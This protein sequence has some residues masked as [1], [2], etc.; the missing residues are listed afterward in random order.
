MSSLIKR[1][2]ST[3][4]R[5]LKNE[6]GIPLDLS[7]ITERILVCSCP[8]SKFPQKLYRNSLNDL[9]NYMEIK[10]SDNWSLWN[11]KTENLDDY[12]WN[13]KLLKGK[14]YHFPWPDHQ[15][16]PFQ[17]LLN[18]VK[19]IHA[20]LLKDP[21]N[22]AVLH[23]K[24]GK[25]RS[26][27][28]ATAY[29]IVYGALTKSEACHLF[30]EKRMNLGFGEGISILSQLKYLDYCSIYINRPYEPQVSPYI[31]HIRV[32]GCKIPRSALNLTIFSYIGKDYEYYSL[33]SIK[34]SNIT[35]QNE[36][37]CIYR[38]NEKIQGQDIRI[39]I[40][41][42]S[43]SPFTNSVSTWFNTYWETLGDNL[44]ADK[45]VFK[46]LWDEFDGFKGTQFKGKKLFDSL[47]IYFTYA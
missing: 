40:E 23:C 42:N 25:G 44:Q 24:M 13:H 41:S 31:N 14:L 33:N 46:C 39:L 16:P 22:V 10:H 8:V 27:L 21:K 1:V 3:P 11:F 9:L 43:S 20:F 37:F 36:N 19:S 17:L 18:A 15:A 6:Y 35:L 2:A 32:I 45:G 4:T 5:S 38:V 34:Y 30:T 28:I 29:L 12:S 26:G 47:E 7:Y